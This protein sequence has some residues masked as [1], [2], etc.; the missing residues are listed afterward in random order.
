[1]K[2][3]RNMKNINLDILNSHLFEAIE[4]LKNNSDPNASP[5]EK[6]DAATAGTIADI[7]KV[8]VDG[9]KVKAQ[10]LQMMSKSE[11]PNATKSLMDNSGIL[12][13]PEGNN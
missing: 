6:M 8:I 9:Y 11:N 10:V 5:N 1:M 7:G 4:M 12:K 2:N 3:T 13:L